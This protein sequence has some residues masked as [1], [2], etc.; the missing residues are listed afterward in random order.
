[1]HF[2]RGTNMKSFYIDVDHCCYDDYIATP[3]GKDYTISGSRNH[4]IF[5]ELRLTLH[6][7]GY[8]IMETNSINGDMVAKDFYLNDVP[9]LAHNRFVSASPIKR[10]LTSAKEDMAERWTDQEITKRD[11]IRHRRQQGG[12]NDFIRDATFSGFPFS[13]KKEDKAESIEVIWTDSFDFF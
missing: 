3:P 10:E 1:M 13:V 6:E 12:Y 7:L 5:E 9:F 4:T 11:V 2:I 8:I